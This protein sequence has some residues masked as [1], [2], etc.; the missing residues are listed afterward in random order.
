[1]GGELK[2]NTFFQYFPT[3]AEPVLYDRLDPVMLESFVN[4]P[5]DLSPLAAI[6][7]A[8]HEVRP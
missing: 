5:A 6:R 8:M 7:A 1:L 4:Q 3:K 2:C